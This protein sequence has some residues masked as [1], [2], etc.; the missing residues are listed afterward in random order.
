MNGG[1]RMDEENLLESNNVGVLV[2][3]GCVGVVDCVC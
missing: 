3:V 1:R 2:V